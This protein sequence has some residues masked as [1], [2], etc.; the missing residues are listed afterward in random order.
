MKLYTK[1]LLELGISD[2][3][4]VVNDIEREEGIV[5][6]TLLQEFLWDYGEFVKAIGKKISSLF[7]EDSIERIDNSFYV[8]KV[9]KLHTIVSLIEIYN[10][11]LQEHFPRLVTLEDVEPIR[12]G[13]SIS[14]V[15]YPFHEH[16][17]LLSSIGRGF[18]LHAYRRG[19]VEATY[20]EL[21]ATI[22]FYRS[23]E[24]VKRK[25]VIYRAIE[26][27]EYSKLLA[28]A[29]LLKRLRHMPRD[30][31]LQLLRMLLEFER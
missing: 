20:R 24:V 29:E 12:F 23:R 1:Y 5:S 18:L 11:L 14:H 31:N 15:K 16:W 19:I 25:R 21:N 26:I 30:V 8:V 2:A 13:I 22:R 7:P 6:P 3:D 27:A 10:R 9:E 28:E 17:R 4:E